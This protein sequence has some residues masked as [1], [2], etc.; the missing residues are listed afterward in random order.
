MSRSVFLSSCGDPF[1]TLLSLKFFQERFYDEVDKFYIN[2]NNH[3]DVPKEVVGEFLQRASQEKKV[4][5][6]YHPTGIGNGMPITEMALISKE[7]LIMLIEDDGYIFEGGEVNRAFQQIESDLVDVVGSPRFSCGN[8]IG[9]AS[10]KKYGLDYSAYGDV[11]PNFWPCFFFVKR[12]DLL[13]TDLDFGSHTFQAG[14]YSKELEH[15]F[16]EI[17]HGDTMVW[18]SIQL[19]A[20]GLRFGSVPQHKADVYEITSKRDNVMNWH[21]TQQPFKWIHG[22]SLSAGYGGYLSGRLPDVSNDS[23]KQ[24]MESRVAFWTI[25]SDVIDGFTEFKKEYKQGIENLIIGCS[26]DKERIR[27]KIKIYRDLMKI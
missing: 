8:E 21:P 3:C 13:K 9:E 17:N 5:L 12:K 2:F 10:K 4:H 14:E 27:V 19:R 22:G 7:D 1:L 26:L 25:C 16:K 18:M 20:L 11:G 15:T 6:I 23:A 24:E